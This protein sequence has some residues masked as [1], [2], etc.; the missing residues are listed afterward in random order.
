MP[1]M[2]GM[3]GIIALS[4][5]AIKCALNMFTENDLKVKQVLVSGSQGKLAIKLPKV[6]NKTTGKMINAPFLFSEAHWTK[7]T[8]SFIK[9]ISSK[10]AGIFFTQI[11]LS[12]AEL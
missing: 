11:S 12:Y 1:S 7:V 10:P 6:L 8:T 2:G 5:T 9:S 4:T 3:L